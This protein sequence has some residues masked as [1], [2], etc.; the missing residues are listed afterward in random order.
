MPDK[1]RQHF[2]SRM[3]LR[4]FAHS[5]SKELICLYHIPTRRYVPKA[6]IKNQAYEDYFYDKGGEVEGA[7]ADMEGQ[8][9][10]RLDW[11][12]ASETLPKW[13]SAEHRDLL[14]FVLSQSSRT[15]AAADEAAEHSRMTLQKASEIS[16]GAPPRPDEAN[17]NAG[18]APAELLKLSLV[19]C[20]AAVDLRYKLLRNL[21]GREF[22]T[23]DHPV[24]CYNQFCE[25]IRHPSSGAG[26][27]CRGLQVFFPLSSRFLLILFD[28]AIYKVGE[29]NFKLDCVGV[30]DEEEVDQLNTLQVV[31]GGD[32]L[33]FSDATSEA[34]IERLVRKARRHMRR[35]RA[36][37]ARSRRS[38]PAGSAGP[39]SQERK[40]MFAPAWTLGPLEYSRRPGITCRT[41]QVP[42]SE[43]LV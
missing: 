37:S 19:G 18:M 21:T 6:P 22:I 29:R 20:L 13:R 40:S 16:R 12:M 5:E 23:S 7:L 8:M 11:V 14:M 33:Y 31:N 26:I 24:V 17:I 4:R 30:D 36:R 25:R 27:G 3:V 1:K 28:S 43:T 41:T 32:H 10:P 15:R 39:S 35:K 42:C 9:R 38:W 2:V 34:Y